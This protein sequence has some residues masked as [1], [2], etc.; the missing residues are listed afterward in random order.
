MSVYLGSMEF[1]VAVTLQPRAGMRLLLIP[2]LGPYNGSSTGSTSTGTT[3]TAPPLV[4]SWPL[5]RSMS[6]RYV[7]R[8]SPESLQA[9]LDYRMM[10]RRRSKSV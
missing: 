8:P 1:D 7:G 4:E 5:T 6:D 10:A 9:C 3:S 2:N